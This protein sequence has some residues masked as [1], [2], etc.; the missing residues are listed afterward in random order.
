MLLSF[1]W[2]EESYSDILEEDN[3]KHYFRV[4]HANN[5]VLHF[6]GDKSK[7]LDFRF[8]DIAKFKNF[9]H[10]IVQFL[11]KLI[12]LTKLTLVAKQTPNP[13]LFSNSCSLKGLFNNYSFLT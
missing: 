4:F 10:E 9:P 13:T 8:A 11:L 12:I 3:S 6:K 1:A 7:I 2:K 5:N